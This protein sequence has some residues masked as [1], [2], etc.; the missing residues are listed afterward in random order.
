MPLQPAESRLVVPFAGTVSG[1]GPL[2]WGEKALLQDQRETG[3]ALNASG[4]QNL[5]QGTTA[6]S[7][8]A[9]LGRLLS[10]QPALRVR[11]GTDPDGTLYQ[12]VHSGGEVAVEV[13]DFAASDDPVEVA[14]YTERLWQ[15][16]LIEPIDHFADWPARMG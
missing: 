16:W 2:T 8:A 1:R 11:L 3:L 13:L 15:Q 9:R 12:Q 4:A 7:A 14:A 6:E 10:K 5:A